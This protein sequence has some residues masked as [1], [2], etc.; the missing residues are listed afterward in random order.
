MQS[1]KR[2]SKPLL[3]QYYLKKKCQR[4]NETADSDS[5]IQMCPSCK[6]NS[7]LYDVS[8]GETVCSNCGIVI[9]DRAEVIE[10]NPKTTNRV[11]MPVSLVF[12]DKG[13]S[14]VITNSNTDSSGTYLNQDQISS[15]SRIRHFDKI[16]VNNRTEIRNLKNAFFIMAM[17]KDKLALTDPVMERSAYYY[18]KALE[19]KLIKG[20]SI[21]EVVVASIYASCKEMNVPRR[22][23]EIAQVAN[24][25]YKFAGRCYRL[26]AQQLGTSS[27]I[28]DA[29]GYISKIADN[30]DVN[31]KTYR[32]AVD[33]LDEVKK[34][35]ISFGKDPSCLATAVLYC[36]CLM[37]QED[38]ISLA[39]IARA[40]GISIV[41][42]RKRVSDIL[43]ALQS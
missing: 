29:S 24:A 43:E 42:L 18:R 28:V 17:I 33:M 8:T 39:R 22:V 10:N 25:D 11:G 38:K 41:T 5:S 12:P 1:R 2:K 14:T 4:D 3:Y 30:A 27:S 13:L 9:L 7:M 26:M 34:N 15:I 20:R 21:R 37:E 35:S 16:S 32:R 40:G 31:Q 36:A 19:K 23:E 6:L